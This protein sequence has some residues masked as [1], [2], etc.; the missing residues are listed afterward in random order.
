MSPQERTIKALRGT[1]M[2]RHLKV[3]V[4]SV[5]QYTGGGRKSESR[6]SVRKFSPS[7]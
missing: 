3:S 7:Y 2:Q 5:K 4:A 1:L 6:Y